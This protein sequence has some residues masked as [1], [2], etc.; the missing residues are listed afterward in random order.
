MDPPDPPLTDGVVWLRPADERDTHAIERGI[1][2]PEVVR[3]FGQPTTSA[4]DVLELNRARSSQRVAERTGS[5]RV[6]LLPSNA[7]KDGH[8]VDHV[9][10]SLVADDVPA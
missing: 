4:R 6:G 2:D 1:T 8:R 3:W 10:F 7:E 5:R 9:V